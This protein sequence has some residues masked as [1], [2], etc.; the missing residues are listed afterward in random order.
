METPVQAQVRK[1]RRFSRYARAFCTLTFVFLGLAV[2]LLLVSVFIGGHN[3]VKV[4]FGAYDMR[5]D[6]LTTFGMKAWAIVVVAVIFGLLFKGLY[7]LRALFGKFIDG[8]IFTKETVRQIRNIGWVMLAMPLAVCLMSLISWGLLKA[9]FVDAASV[10]PRTMGL[11]PGALGSFIPP[12]LILLASW[13]MDVGRQTQEEA[14]QLR[15]D[16]ELVV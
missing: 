16:A 6:Q 10:S 9:G 12:A 5:T 3:G 4:G 1:V 13:V 11:T 15:R 7:H 14:E 2:L 8:E